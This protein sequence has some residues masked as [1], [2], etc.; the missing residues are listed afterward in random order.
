[1]RLTAI[2]ACI[3]WISAGLFET[4]IGSGTFQ[5]YI[6]EI[7]KDENEVEDLMNKFSKIN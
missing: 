3:L 4:A 2:T 6:G 1:M 5:E 7:S